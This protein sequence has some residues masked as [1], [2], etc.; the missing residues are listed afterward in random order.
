MPSDIDQGL[1]ISSMW[2]MSTIGLSGVV[3]GRQCAHETGSASVMAGQPFAVSAMGDSMD[4]DLL[5]E[6]SVKTWVA[7]THTHGRSYR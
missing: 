1:S 6:L 3:A 4:S 2:S 7:A 5:P